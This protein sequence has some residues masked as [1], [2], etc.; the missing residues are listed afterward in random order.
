MP[1]WGHDVLPSDGF[2]DLYSALNQFEPAHYFMARNFRTG[3]SPWWN[4][5]S[6][7]G[8]LGP[9][10]L[11]DIKFSPHTLMTTWLF[12]ASP[13][14][15][16][17]GLLALYCMGFYF[18]LC[19]FLDVFRTS[20]CAA[21]VGAAAYL[22]NGFAVPNLNTG[23]GQP[24]FLFPIVL[25]ALLQF[26]Q[27]RDLPSWLF[28]VFAHAV[29][30][31]ANIMT[32]LM[33]T[34]LAVH[35]LGVAFY[36]GLAG[37]ARQGT[38][39][40]PIYC[41]HIVLAVVCAV[42]LLGFLWV[43]VI[44]SFFVTDMV[45]DFD[46]RMLP[47]PIGIENF[48]SIF[49]PQHFWDVFGHIQRVD[50][51]PDAGLEKK[52]PHITY[53]GITTF[54]VA[55]CALGRNK[56]VQHWV[57]CVG[58][59]LLVFA[60]AR[61]F[62]AMGFVDHLPV[63]HS[64]GNQYWGCMAAV[65]LPVLVALGVQNIREEKLPIVAVCVI[66][67]LPM[68]GFIYL[69]SRLG[70]PSSSIQMLH[71]VIAIVLWIS[72]VLWWWLAKSKTLNAKY[73][74]VFI[75][76]ALIAELL[77]YM[78]TVRPMRYGIA[79]TKPSV[80]QFLKKN[81][82]DGRIL[83][84]GQQGV[85]YPEYGAL[86]GIRQAGT[87]N[88]GLLSWYESFF[89]KYF[90]NDTF[91]FLALDGSSNKKRKKTSRKEFSLD[92]AALD[93]DSI[94]YIVVSKTADVAYAENLQRDGYPLVYSDN[95]AL[96]FENKNYLPSLSLVSA[97]S[98][99]SQLDPHR[100]AITADTALKAQAEQLGIPVVDNSAESVVV[101]GNV[102]PLVRRNTEVTAKVTVTQPAILVLSDTWHPDWRATVDGVPAYIG[103]VNEAFRGIVLPA[104]EHRVCFYYDPPALRYGIYISIMA[105]FIFLLL[106]LWSLLGRRF[107]HERRAINA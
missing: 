46:K 16:D 3:D 60:Y 67:L 28:V 70:M 31:L 99:A 24:Y 96:V 89:E 8:T 17:F 65:V 48:L 43:P 71:V 41:L 10:T 94:K 85:L 69:Y 39:G 50:L 63:L 84:I 40:F 93:A 83:N 14:S 95:T 92:A 21:L 49:S 25:F 57:A 82:G 38:K 53:L 44:D 78:N 100:V 86:F 55:V 30:L 105:G 76:L 6:A 12:D 73:L 51:Y 15:F 62:G 68:V 47:K 52:S 74:S 9:E 101:M 37:G 58:I 5:Y 98:T 77:S 103:R 80:V 2:G 20:W 61:V 18:M 29:I 104:G 11:I 33:L 22:L 106:L 35:V 81:I 97:L 64:I 56:I 32:T 23:I 42:A 26:C 13:V 90:G 1:V 102:Q 4:P 88:A 59:A 66:L 79:D 36:V 7:S 75:S 27:R 19:I 45:S 87:M 91:F 54:L 107:F 72:S 34:L